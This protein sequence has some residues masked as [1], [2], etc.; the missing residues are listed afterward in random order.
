MGGGGRGLKNKQK[1]Y[2]STKW[3]ESFYIMCPGV[4]TLYYKCDL[5][6]QDIEAS[7]SCALCACEKKMFKFKLK[8]DT[9]YHAVHV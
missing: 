6:E 2:A 5:L 3:M 1:S 8:W 4:C 7:V 9:P